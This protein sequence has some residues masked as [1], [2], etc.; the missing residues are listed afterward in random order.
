MP[1][2]EVEPRQSGPAQAAGPHYRSDI[3]GS[4]AIAVLLVVGY[5]VGIP[6]LS[7]GYVGVDVFF[8]LSGYLI[9][10]LLV[11]EHQDQGRIDFARFYARRARRLLPAAVLVL[12][13]TLGLGVLLLS[14]LEQRDLGQTGVWV[15]L[16]VAN[17]LFANRSTQYF[18]AG[19]EADPLLHTW[20]LSVEEQFYLVWPLT[21][22]VLAWLGLRVLG[23]R[24]LLLAG[25][26]AVAVV[27]LLLCLWLTPIRQP[28]AF[29]TSPPR[30][31]EFGVG[32]LAALVATPTLERHRGILGAAGLIGAALVVIAA[33]WFDSFTA[34]PGSAVAL[35]VIGTT[36]LLVA[37]AGGGR[38]GLTRGLSTGPM[39]WLG[40]HSYSWYLWHWPLLIYLTVF[41]PAPSLALKVMTALT[42]LALSAVTFTFVEQ[43]VRYRPSLT[44]RP[45]RSIGLGLGLSA[46]G[47]VAALLVQAHGVGASHRP[48]Q[49]A[50]TQ[51]AGDV[52]EV[53]VDDCIIGFERVEPD[54]SCVY[55][56]V[57]SPTTVVLFGDSHAGAWFPAVEG[58]ARARGWRLVVMTKASC[59][60]PEVSVFL[61]KFH[62]P[63]VECD[64]WRERA[65][66]EILRLRPTLTVLANFSDYVPD[67]GNG[68]SPQGVNAEEWTAGTRATAERLEAAGLTQVLLADPPTPRADVPRC[69][70][71]RASALV[72]TDDCSLDRED[73]L[74]DALRAADIEAMA[75]IDDSAVVDLTDVFCPT[76]ACSVERDGVVVYYDGHH[77]SSSFSATLA[78]ELD[79]RIEAAVRPRA[80]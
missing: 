55:G 4:R 8:V 25:M 66:D 77:L 73:G 9:T 2:A 69:L 14:P 37:G 6:G 79:D 75:D 61:A 30:F 40:R 42:G 26:V 68:A 24:R 49:E 15:A 31:W 23:S 21:L 22:A 32:G 80:G 41:W 58:V 1:Q 5:H 29:F 70:A 33:T 34:Y 48:E 53:V 13:V 52:P 35:P 64:E 62:R 74:N 3:E 39:Q 20:S 38:S 59:P 18:G 65:I 72:P 45:G 78:G 50:L 71:R 56:D 76:E 16:Y 28:Y 36:M 27:S 67:G 63:F 17:I 11:R 46:V 57:A 7:G 12:V 51:A 54:P 60:T 10:G 44:S 19:V 43:P 47:V